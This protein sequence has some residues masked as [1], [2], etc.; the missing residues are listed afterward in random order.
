MT[1]ESAAWLRMAVKKIE[2]VMIA[3][4]V[5]FNLK[6]HFLPLM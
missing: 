6:L 5:V 2:M 3:I 1:L 4:I